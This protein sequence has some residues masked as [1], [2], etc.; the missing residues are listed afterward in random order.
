MLGGWGA[1]TLLPVGQD[2]CLYGPSRWQGCRTCLQQNAKLSL[3]YR[4][5]SNL[6]S[7]PP[8]RCT[9]VVQRC[10]ASLHP[11]SASLHRSGIAPIPCAAS[12]LRR[13]QK[14]KVCTEPRIRCGAGLIGYAE[15]GDDSPLFP[16]PAPSRAN[17][18]TRGRTPP[19]LFPIAAP[20]REDLL[21]VSRNLRPV[22][23][24]LRDTGGKP[25]PL[26]ETLQR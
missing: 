13:D 1:S 21:D 16:H 20:L 25:L 4:A 8:H 24:S 5:P 22:R 17:A 6:C 3:W 14:K 2:A 7:D 12:D 11:Y 23:E 19:H 18:A 26:G 9:F 10:N 15:A